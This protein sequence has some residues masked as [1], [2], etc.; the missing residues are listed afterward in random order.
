MFHPIY[1][2]VFVRFLLLAQRHENLD[3]KQLEITGCSPTAVGY[4]CINNITSLANH[5]MRI[6]NM[7]GF[8]FHTV[9]AFCLVSLET[10]SGLFYVG[11]SHS[12]CPERS[13]MRAWSR[14]L[15]T[16]KMMSLINLPYLIIDSIRF[17]LFHIFF[18]V[19]YHLCCRKQRNTWCWSGDAFQSSGCSTTEPVD[20]YFWCVSP[21]YN[22]YMHYVHASHRQDMPL[23]HMPIL[24]E[25][26]P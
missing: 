21:M 4:I 12:I 10:T 18:G 13:W 19:L 2:S 26:M 9:K 23:G 17:V 25:V 14:F 3:W 11:I 6:K 24:G 22:M 5:N 1:D 8:G 20:T 7:S 16:N 15:I